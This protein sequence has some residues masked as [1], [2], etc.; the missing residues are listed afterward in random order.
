MRGE[1]YTQLAFGKA[2]AS[3]EPHFADDIALE[4]ER[5]T[6]DFDIL[7]KSLA[8][9][10]KVTLEILI[11]CEDLHPQVSRLIRVQRA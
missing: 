10:S 11:I 4:L 2:D 3:R 5:N 7:K 8:K 9:G 1:K 6:Y